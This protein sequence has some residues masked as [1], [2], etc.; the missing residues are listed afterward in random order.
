VRSPA[1][2]AA[3][4]FLV[5][6]A[7]A[8]LLW[9]SLSSEHIVCGVG[10]ASLALLAAAADEEVPSVCAALVIGFVF[11][12]LS[13]GIIAAERAYK[14]PLAEWH[15][16][17][18]TAEPVTLEG[19]LREDAAQTP[20]GAS[21]ALDIDRV[22]SQAVTGGVR[23]SIVGALA[24]GASGDWRRGR[25]V[26][27][28]ATLRTPS[29]YHDPGVPELRRPLARRGVCLVGSVKSATLVERLADA[30][31]MLEA[32]GNV[33]AWVRRRLAASIGPWSERSAAVT[34]AILIGDRSRLSKDD[35]Q[36]L[37]DAGTY[38]VIAISGGNIALVTVILMLVSRVLFLPVAVGAASTIGALLFY[39]LITGP[40]PSVE[41]AVT[42]AVIFLAARLIDHRGP[43][44]NAL[45]VAAVFG[46][47]RSPAAILDPGFIL[48]FGA[49]L[50]ILVGAP[51]TYR[52]AQTFQRK[53]GHGVIDAFGR[54]ALTVLVATVC[55]ELVLMPVSA[56]L[57]GRVT[58][59]GL[60]LNFVA[61]P[62]MIV[63]QIAGALTLV[64]DLWSTLHR[65]TVVAASSAAS[66]L[67][68]SAR[69]VEIAPWLARSVN[70]PWWPLMVL[71]YG[72]L[73]GTVSRRLRRRAVPWA[74]ALLMLML[75]GPHALT[76]DAVPSSPLPLRVVVLDVG[77]GDASVVLFPDGHALLVDAGGA[78]PLP[79]PDAETESGFDVGARVVAPALHALGASH[80]EALLLTH[81]DPD[82]IL[83]V[84]AVFHQFSVRSVWE[85]V[86]VPP[87]PGLRAIQLLAAGTGSTWR[88]MQTG[89]RER[90]GDVEARVLHPP[91]P[92]WERQRVRNEDSVV[93][94]LRIGRVSIVLAGDIGKEGERAILSHL[95]PERL[96]VL[97]AGHHGS[98]T[99][100]TPELLS[101][102]RPSAVI[103]SA[104]RDNRFGHPHPMVVGRFEALGTTIFRTDADGAVF[105][106]TDGEVVQVRGW[107]GRAA[108][109]TRVT[110]T[111]R[112]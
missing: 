38:H 77:Q 75:A 1:A 101:V 11:A 56:S 14:S 69:L 42:A 23:L 51:L 18:G 66:G 10:A 108:V 84:P 81:G 41:R 78:G 80:L 70:P 5:G 55:A 57:F 106:E 68:E 107:T 53:R 9:P 105:V 65:A 104:G 110:P 93:L 73:A 7:T 21:V 22:G 94:E 99:S 90:F 98:A 20:F 45:A 91:L 109:L 15:E 63:V 47:A 92:E 58:F 19:V 44:L 86:P 74:A 32:A 112:P 62:L 76:R 2:L 82:H 49:T 43:P 87:H 67:V 61:I 52:D 54:A 111:S 31:F 64:P 88:T 71:Y 40:T 37:Q 46:V 26:R 60:L 100:S 48:S 34:T 35:E 16:T 28:T 72:A 85:G 24:L 89:D 39:A 6:T 29:E 102:M 96:F 12:G 13:L 4:P 50:A 95:E 103:F 97:K 27:V 8:L 79:A 3:I 25:R 30:S 33:R 59:A 36:R 83:G 17:Q